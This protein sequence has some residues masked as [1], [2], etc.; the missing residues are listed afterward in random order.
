MAFNDVLWDKFKIGDDRKITDPETKAPARRNIFLR[1]ENGAPKYSVAT[2]IN[3][4]SSRGM[5]SL[6]C[7]VS[8]SSW[9][10]RMS[11]ELKREPAEVR[12]EILANLIPGAIVVPSGIYALL[13]AQNAGC[14]YM[15]AGS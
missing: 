13:R 9:T 3:T 11:R 2:K 4:L 6:V 15:Q 5:I 7:N 14:A 8:L 12:A 1:P 10:S